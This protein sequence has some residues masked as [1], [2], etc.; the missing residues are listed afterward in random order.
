[1]ILVIVVLF[2]VIAL[3]L[4]ASRVLN[5]TLPDVP[6]EKVAFGLVVVALLALVPTD[7]GRLVRRDRE[8][9]QGR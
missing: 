6:L 5:L 2:N 7:L 1:M 4:L 8:P 9:R 3:R